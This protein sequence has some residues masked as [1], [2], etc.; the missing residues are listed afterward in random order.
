MEE[1]ATPAAKRVAFFFDDLDYPDKSLID[2][3]QVFFKLNGWMP[4]F[5]VFKPHDDRLATSMETLETLPKALNA[6]TYGNMKVSG[7]SLILKLQLGGN[8]G[9]GA[10]G[11]GFGLTTRGVPR[12]Q[13]YWKTFWHTTIV[14]S[15]GHRCLARAAVL[16][17]RCSLREKFQLQS[18]DI[19]GPHCDRGFQSVSWSKFPN[20][21]GQRYD[22]KNDHKLLLS[23]QQTGTTFAWLLDRRR[24]DFKGAWFQRTPFWCSR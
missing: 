13:V 1:P 21:L 8:R 15:A 18:I 12:S 3:M 2:D 9:R 5:H 7:K 10:K 14:Q 4:R 23:T 17:G 11:L 6:T 20:I 22:L 24:R 19:F 16:T